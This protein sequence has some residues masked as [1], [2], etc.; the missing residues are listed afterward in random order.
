MI[1]SKTRR[2]VDQ[3]EVE[4]RVPTKAVHELRKKNRLET[5][6][7]RR[8]LSRAEFPDGPGRGQ[9]GTD[10]MI[11]LLKGQYSLQRQTE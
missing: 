7:I 3:K 11:A 1:T 10:A 6:D 4:S 2:F 9:D 8:L 5:R